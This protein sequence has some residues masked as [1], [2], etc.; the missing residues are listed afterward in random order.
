MESEVLSRVWSQVWSRYCGVGGLES[1]VDSGMWRRKFGVGCGVEC[2]VG[3]VELGVWSLRCGIVVWS[4]RFRGGVWTVESG[5][6]GGVMESE[7][8]SVESGCLGVL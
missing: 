6:G 2:G 4:R 1:A 3:S 8:S 5:Y 7:V